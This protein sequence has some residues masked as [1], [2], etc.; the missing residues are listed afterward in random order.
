M[1]RKLFYDITLK[2]HH[3]GDEITRYIEYS[4]PKVGDPMLWCDECSYDWE[5]RTGRECMYR[6]SGIEKKAHL[7]EEGDVLDHLDI[8]FGTV[9]TERI[10]KAIEQ[11]EAV[12]II[13]LELSGEITDEE[14]KEGEFNPWRSSWVVADVRFNE[15]EYEFFN[16][17]SNT[18]LSVC[19]PTVTHAWDYIRRFGSPPRPAFGDENGEWDWFED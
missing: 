17:S 12:E 5:E 9:D 19:A 1:K 15:N 6:I 4:P 14:F 18:R 16:L 13:V 2:C 11:G 3:C 8:L 7:K 10:D